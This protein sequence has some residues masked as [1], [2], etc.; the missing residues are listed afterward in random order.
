[1]C[2]ATLICRLDGK[3]RVVTFSVS[4]YWTLSLGINSV[5][6]IKQS[7]LSVR[8]I[9]VCVRW[10]ELPFSLYHV[11]QIF[12]VLPWSFFILDHVNPANS[13]NTFYH[14]NIRIVTVSYG[15]TLQTQTILLQKEQSDQALHC[16][17]DTVLVTNSHGNCTAFKCSPMCQFRLVLY[18]QA[19]F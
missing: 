11:W 17:Y 16:M 19:N 6:A 14:T 13:Y 2:F 9:Y 18:K 8:A 4:H 15:H 1:M 3:Y 10:R 7:S 12:E 5:S